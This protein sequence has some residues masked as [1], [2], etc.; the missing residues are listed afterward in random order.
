MALLGQP[1]ERGLVKVFLGLD[2]RLPLCLCPALGLGRWASGGLMTPVM[3][4]EEPQQG[5]IWGPLLPLSL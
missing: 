1:W 4:L 3:G 2:S 5:I